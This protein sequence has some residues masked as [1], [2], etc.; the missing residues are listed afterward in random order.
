MTWNKQCISWEH[1][2]IDKDEKVC[3]IQSM[4][5]G[6]KS[7]ELVLYSYGKC[8][9]RGFMYFVDLFLLYHEQS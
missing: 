7:I 2:P 1:V 4:G 3:L 5:N 9:K 8:I 6:L